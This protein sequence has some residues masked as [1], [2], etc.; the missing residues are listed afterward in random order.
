[1]EELKACSCLVSQSSPAHLNKVRPYDLLVYILP[2]LLVPLDL[3][4]EVAIRA[5]LHDYTEL[6]VTAVE[7]GLEETNDIWGGGNKERRGE[8]E[9]WERGIIGGGVV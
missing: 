8:G 5:V 3:L 4:C 6:R 9:G 2:A 1:M 7:E